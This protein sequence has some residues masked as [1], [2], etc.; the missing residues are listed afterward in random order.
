M[1]RTLNAKDFLHAGRK[2]VLEE[3]IR[4][5]LYGG[6]SATLMRQAVFSS[7]R[8]GLF[9]AFERLWRGDGK[10]VSIFGRITCAV[11]VGVTGAVLANPTD[12]VL[13]RMQ[14]DGHWPE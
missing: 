6:I 8:Q 5:G 4:N 7:T 12:V 1:K 9:G 3:G 14:A 10:S 2:L 13:I 11:A